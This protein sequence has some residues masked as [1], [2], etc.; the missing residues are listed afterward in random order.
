MCVWDQYGGRPGAQ[1]Y[2]IQRKPGTLLMRIRAGL[3]QYIFR[4]GFS[5]DDTLLFLSANPF[6]TNFGDVVTSNESVDPP[7]PPSREVIEGKPLPPPDIVLEDK[8]VVKTDVLALSI[9]ERFDLSKL[10]SEK[11]RLL[12][13]PIQFMGSDA[14]RLAGTNDDDD[15]IAQRGLELIFKNQ[16]GHFQLTSSKPVK[17]DDDPYDDKG[18][19]W[20][21]GDPAYGRNLPSTSKKLWQSKF[22]HVNGGIGRALGDHFKMD[23]Q[24]CVIVIKSNDT[25]EIWPVAEAVRKSSFGTPNGETCYHKI[26]NQRPDGVYDGLKRQP[27]GCLIEAA[28]TV[29]VTAAKV[30]AWGT[31]YDLKTGKKVCGLRDEKG[32]RS[33]SLGA[34]EP[35]A[36]RHYTAQLDPNGEFLAVRLTGRNTEGF[37]IWNAKNG[38]PIFERGEFTPEGREEEGR[39]KG[40]LEL[41]EDTRVTNVWGKI[42]GIPDVAAIS[43]STDGK[44]VVLANEGGEV[45]VKDSLLDEHA[46]KISGINLSAVIEDRAGQANGQWSPVQFPVRYLDDERL[47]IANYIVDTATWSVLLELPKETEIN[48][49]NS[50]TATWTS[51]GQLEFCDMSFWRVYRSHVIADLNLQNQLL[52][53]QV[54]RSDAREATS[55]SIDTAKKPIP[56]TK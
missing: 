18:L 17:F 37:G 3:H 9:P 11:N 45:F 26:L 20:L 42:A 50:L 36:D 56:R 55:P 8:D 53:L 49:S 28:A 46:T 40:I 23:G 21:D 38:A 13:R 34:I 19:S 27:G 2:V 5:S 44:S 14:I 25:V 41:W 29:N 4:P 54:A 43:W 30:F 6:K 39:E 32:E 48:E 33:V 52:L 10:S 16:S 47:L 7:L 22:A 1:A 35:A 31:I 51:T 24:D 15:S 12:W